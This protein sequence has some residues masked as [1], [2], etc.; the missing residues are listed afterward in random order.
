[1]S[2]RIM[3]RTSEAGRAVCNI[4]VCLGMKIP[5]RGEKRLEKV[6]EELSH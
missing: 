4:P 1:M 6:F 5:V 2:L 3:E